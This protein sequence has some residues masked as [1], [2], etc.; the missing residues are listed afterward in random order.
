MY[1]WVHVNDSGLT[2]DAGGLSYLSDLYGLACDN[3]ANFEVRLS[4]IVDKAVSDHK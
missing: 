1:V 2:N 3:V 4:R